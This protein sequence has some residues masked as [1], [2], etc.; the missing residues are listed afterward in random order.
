MQAEIRS[1]LRELV[2]AQR[3]TFHSDLKARAAARQLN[4][5]LLAPALDPSASQADKEQAILG[6]K[7]TAQYFRENVLQGVPID[8]RENTYSLR[9]TPS[10]A[11]G[12]NDTVKKVAPAPSLDEIK[13]TMNTG[14]RRRRRKA[15]DADAEAA[16]DSAAA[17]PSAGT[18]C[19][20]GEP[21]S[22]PAGS[23]TQRRG[24]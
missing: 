4:R 20:G 5:A 12:D 17:A 3:I 11:L 1:A 10:T 23:E 22:N 9:F 7:Q 19:G 24:A 2:R 18:T 15:K 16:P 21:S 8:D 6:A 13:S 14:A